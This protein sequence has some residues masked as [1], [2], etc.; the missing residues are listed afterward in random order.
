MSRSSSNKRQPAG[1]GPGRTSRPQSGARFTRTISLLL[2]VGVVF[3]VALLMVVSLVD[4]VLEPDSAV[5]AGPMYV[6]LA[7]TTAAALLMLFAALNA[8]YLPFLSSERAR[9][10]QLVMAVMGI[11]GVATGLL[12]LGGAVSFIVTRLVLGSV[13]FMFITMQNARLA[14]ARAAARAG[15]AGPPASQAQPRPRSRQRRGGRKQ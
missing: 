15:Q 10:V 12:T 5:K 2:L 7:F 8:S 1:Q 11:T 4:F 3:L 14:Q 6:T 9:D 13:A